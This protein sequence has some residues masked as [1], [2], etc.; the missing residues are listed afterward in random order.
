MI[1]APHQQREPASRRP[2]PQLRTVAADRDH[3][4]GYC[5]HVDELSRTVPIRGRD[6]LSVLDKVTFAVG[7][8]ELV[9]IVGP[10]G[11]G[12]TMLLEAI[13]GIGPTS[14][15]SVRFDGIDVHS[16]LRKFRGVI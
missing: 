14:T 13:A 7:A 3:A 5:V 12:K 6:D 15:G 1:G 8:G 4:H 9:A 16:N 2:D 10:S 11:A